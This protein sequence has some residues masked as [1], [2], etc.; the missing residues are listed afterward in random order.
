M[1]VL[2][3]SDVVMGSVVF[4]VNDVV[5]V[6]VACIGCACRVLVMFSLLWMCAV[7]VSCVI[8]WFVTCVVMS[9]FSLRL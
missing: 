5:E 4:R 8:S 2:I 7:R 3:A 1:F 6:S 9:W